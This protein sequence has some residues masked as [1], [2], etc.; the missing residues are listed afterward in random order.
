[1]TDKDEYRHQ[2]IDFV[3]N[4]S[5]SSVEELLLIFATIPVSIFFHR[6][7]VSAFNLKPS[8]SITMITLEFCYIVLPLLISFTFTEYTVTLQSLMLSSSLLVYLAKRSY[9]P[10]EVKERIA[11]LS[12]SRKP[13]IEEYRSLMMLSTC[14]AI[15]AVDFTIFPRR[16][17]KCETF[18]V[19]LMD[20]GVGSVVLSGALVSLQA[21]SF[22]QEEQKT[23][24]GSFRLMLMWRAIFSN[25]PLFL[26]GFTRILL[27]KSINYQEHAS[28]YGTHWN[29]FFTLTFVS[30]FLALL[31]VPV[32]W[33]GLAGF[34][35]ISV[36]QIALSRFGLREYILDHPRDNLLHANKEGICSLLGYLSIY[37]IGIQIGGVMFEP[38][39]KIHHWKSLSWKLFVLDGIFWVSGLLAHVYLEPASRRMVN[40]TYVLLVLAYNTLILASLLVISL[41]GRPAHSTILT[42]INRNQLAFFL[43]GN[44]FTGLINLSMKTL[45]AT[46]TVAVG[47]M[48]SYLSVLCTIAV[49][50]D[51][52]NITLK[53]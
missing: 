6:T 32:K 3:S 43:L 1:M 22:A 18:G 7:M 13:F 31:N 17:A 9:S 50:L 10:S 41:F 35:L 19:S 20:M 39:K 52:C 42:A 21:R 5:G 38:R 25:L 47:I 15:L 16:F 48:L 28:E 12:S 44:L 34:L 46:G 30:M 29:F 51:S 8:R 4:L 23:N 14:V 49:V 27:T 40:L 36:Y 26:L 45:Y 24:G 11:S 33:S 37:L 53:L 2:Q